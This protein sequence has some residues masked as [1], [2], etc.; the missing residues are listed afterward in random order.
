MIE[1]VKLGEVFSTG[2]RLMKSHFVETLGIIIL[3]SILSIALDLMSNIAYVGF[4]FSIIYTIVS[5]IYSMGLTAMT[6]KAVD[7]EAP[8]WGVFKETLPRIW[9]YLLAKIILSVITMVSFIVIFTLALTVSGNS[10]TLIMDMVNELSYLQAYH[11][12]DADAVLQLMDELFSVLWLPLLLAYIPALY[13]SLRFYF[14]A[15]LI[16]D[17]NMQAADALRISWKSTAYIQGKMLLFL[18]LLFALNLAG[19][20]CFFVG[21][22]VTMIITVYAQAALYRQIFQAGIQDPLIVENAEMVV[23]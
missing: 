2:W 3:F 17:R 5:V 13:I 8:Y 22:F 7:G 20:L 9:Q 21:I 16:I 15:F 18:A 23:D 11:P 14:T 6:V 10:V 4:I 1:T 19:V 12:E